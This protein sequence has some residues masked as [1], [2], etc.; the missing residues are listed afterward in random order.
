MVCF[1]VKQKGLKIIASPNFNLGGFFLPIR[2]KTRGP[3]TN[4]FFPPLS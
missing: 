3:L 2:F 1:H 4:P